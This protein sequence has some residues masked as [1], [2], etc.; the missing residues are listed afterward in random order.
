MNAADA[1]ELYAAGLAMPDNER[2]RLM[3]AGAALQGLLAG[4]AVAALGG[5]DVWPPDPLPIARRA[6]AYADATLLLHNEGRVYVTSPM[7]SP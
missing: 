1:K 4:C 2:A 6:L 5:A 7:P 3:L